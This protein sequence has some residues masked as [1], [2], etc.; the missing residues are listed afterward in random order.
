MACT[1]LKYF[2]NDIIGC[3]DRMK[4]VLKSKKIGVSDKAYQLHSDTLRNTKYHIKKALG[5]AVTSY[6][7]SDNCTIF[8]RAITPV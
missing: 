2:Q 4:A 3:F 7:I 1:T 5:T 8:G 6:S